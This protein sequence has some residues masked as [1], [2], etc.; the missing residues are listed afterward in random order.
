MS[1]IPFVAV[2]EA[3]TQAGLP[4]WQRPHDASRPPDLR[5][6]CDFGDDGAVPMMKRDGV[7]RV[8][9]AHWS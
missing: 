8:Q 1:S 3:A 4:T 6:H 5:Q 2:S 9:A 7:G